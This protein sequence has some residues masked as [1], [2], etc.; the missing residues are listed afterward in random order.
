MGLF[1][2]FKKSTGKNENQNLP[3]EISQKPIQPYT[4]KEITPTPKYIPAKIF[5]LL[6]FADGPYINYVPKADKNKFNVGNLTF[7]IS[8]IGATEPSAIYC[9]APIKFHPDPTNIPKMNYFPSYSQMTPEQRWLYLNWLINIDLPIDIGYVF[10]FYYGLERHLFFSKYEEAFK[11]VLQLRKNHRNKSFLSYSSG[12]LLASCML[13][14]RPDLFMLYL[15]NEA[16]YIEIG[17]SSLYT[18]AKFGMGLNL[19]AD[20]LIMLSKEVG[21][22]NSKYIKEEQDLFEQELKKIMIQKY[23]IEEIQI[24]NFPIINWPRKQE[25]IA[26][27][28]SLDQNQRTLDIPCLTNYEP[29]R[30]EACELLKQTHENVKKLLKEGKSLKTAVVL[31]PQEI[32]QEKQQPSNVFNKS[33]LFTAIDVT[34]FDQNVEYYNKAICPYCKKV[35]PTR[36]S[37]KSKCKL[38]ENLIYV[39]NNIFTTE[40]AFLTEVDNSSLEEIKTER[41][42]RNF[43]LNMLQNES[44]TEKEAYEIIKKNNITIEN[45]LVFICQENMVKHKLKGNMGLY[46]NSILNTGQIYHKFGD[47]KSALNYFLKVCFIDLNGPNNGLSILYDRSFAFLAPAVVSWVCEISNDLDIENKSLKKL[48]LKNAYEVYDKAMPLSPENAFKELE[49]EL[50]INN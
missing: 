27:N 5:D 2:K 1:D 36:P 37:S 44:T 35:M 16:E 6:W 17:L 41:A 23:G 46:R 15:K 33:I 7:E 9:K 28:Y 3:I 40:R 13:N 8:F 30:L 49:K 29:F 45:A 20:D 34:L 21:F 48:F 47:K 19:T 39:K 42:N 31:K 4:S 14:K 22:S 10:V 24:A 43:I 26:A 25:L 18:M 38:C 12:A 11:T 50:E 32:H